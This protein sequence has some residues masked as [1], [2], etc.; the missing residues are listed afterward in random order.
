MDLEGLRDRD[1]P[2]QLQERLD[3]KAAEEKAAAEAAAAGKPLPRPLK[4]VA[5]AECGGC[6]SCAGGRSKGGKDV[7]AAASNAPQG[8]WDAQAEGSGETGTA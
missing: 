4:A 8:G 3:A 6:F 5:S 1:A 7:E 2:L